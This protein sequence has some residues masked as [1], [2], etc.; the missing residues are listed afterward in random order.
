MAELPALIR[1]ARQ[2]DGDG[3][4]LCALLARQGRD[5][6]RSLPA[7]SGGNRA[8]ERYL[9]HLDD[10]I[11]CLGQR[12]LLD[13]LLRQGYAWLQVNLSAG[14]LIFPA[15]EQ[16]AQGELL[17]MRLVLLPEMAG[18]LLAGQVVY[19]EHFGGSRTGDPWQ[20]AVEYVHILESDRDLICA[21][22]MRLQTRPDRDS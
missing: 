6:N 22:V 3:F 7:A 1:Q 18:V 20:T 5:M 17:A 15:P 9:R 13:E 8:L 4:G 12:F 19:C 11:N 16:Y 10:R 2:P 14:G 21:H